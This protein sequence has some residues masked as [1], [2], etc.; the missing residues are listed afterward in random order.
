MISDN[1]NERYLR[2]ILIFGDSGQKLLR[3]SH[4]F[5]AGCGGL[6]S[7]IAMYLTAAGIG[8]LTIVDQ[9]T[10]SV[11]NL[12]RQL[13]HWTGDIGKEKV[14][15]ARE[16]LNN[17]NPEVWVS[18]IC[19][20]ITQDTIKT[21]AQGADIIIDAVDNMDTRYILNQY[22]VL[23]TTPFIHGAVNGLSGEMMVILPGKTACLRCLIRDPTKTGVIPVLGTTAGIIGLMQ[24]NEVI[25]LI[26]GIGVVQEGRIVIWDGNSGKLE[27]YT[28]RKLDSC[29][30]CGDIQVP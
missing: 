7:P 5:I 14:I 20:S 16:K 4:I 9:D 29:P 28:V 22:A 10:V 6:G 18:C 11:S 1:K 15:S 12:N 13:L 19:E 21:L 24:A 25:K 27:G 3:N 23:T 26:T 8:R 2:Q 30:I 17:L